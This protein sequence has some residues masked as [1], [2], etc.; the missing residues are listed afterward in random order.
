MKIFGP[1]PSRRLGQ[2]LG[3]NNIPPKNC[4]YSCGYCQVGKSL[5]M[6]INRRVY[7]GP[8]EIYGLVKEKIA[9]AS[10]YGEN[11]DYLTFVPDGEPT[12]DISLGQEIE[13]L[14]LTGIRVAVITNGSLLWQE[15]VRKDLMKADLVSVKMDAAEK[16]IWR[17]INHPHRE[18]D[19]PT[20]LEGIEVFAREFKGLLLTETMLIDGV[21]DAPDHIRQLASLIFQVDPDKAYLAIPTR[22]PADMDVLPSS[23]TRINECFQIFSEKISRVEYLI[24][25]EGNAFA[26]TG[27]AEEDILSITAVHPMREDSIKELIR[28]AHA[29]QGIVDKLVSQGKLK[30]T[31]FGGNKYYMRKL[32]RG[33]TV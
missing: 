12:L 13:L 28:K 17:Q 33:I 9:A 19:L 29:R 1:V 31:S 10:S 11:I 21:N 22:P 14:K 4:T 6:E 8:E 3:I 5:E 2:S 30:V 32:E 24:G 20:V 18:L 15:D 16:S 7:Y 27:D 23:E 26:F 25:F